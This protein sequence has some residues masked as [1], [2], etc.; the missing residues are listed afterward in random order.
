M[1]NQ[2]FTVGDDPQLEVKIGSG[3]LRVLSGDTGSIEISVRG[4]D[5]NL[6]RLVIEQRGNT[7]IV[8]QRARRLGS[9]DITAVVPNGTSIHA[10]LASADLIADADVGSLTVEVASGDVVVGRVLSDASVVTASGDVRIASVGGDAHV[11]T[12]SGDVKVGDVGGELECQT[13]SGDCSVGTAVRV[14]AKTA[15]GDL[16]VEAF[17]GSELAFKTM[18]GDARIG[19]LAGLVL[20][21][22]IQTMS[23]EVRN[24]FELSAQAGESKPAALSIK[25]M[26][27]DVT[28]SSA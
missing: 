12:A 5:R 26:S 4:S 11:V 14:N 25:T 7:V 21:V 23:G 9:L 19:L 13:A 6:E 20:D 8:Q 28:L 16:K 17:G 2:F 24:E 15:S 18:S 3:S 1:T 27:G 22:D 10:V